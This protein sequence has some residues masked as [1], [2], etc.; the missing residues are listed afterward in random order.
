MEGTPHP[1]VLD[2]TGHDI[3]GEAAQLAGH[4]PATLVELPG[5]MVA[6]SIISQKCVRTFVGISRSVKGRVNEPAAACRGW[7]RS[8]R[9]GATIA[10][11]GFG[12]SPRTGAIGGN[13][14]RRI[15]EIN[16]AARVGPGVPERGHGSGD[17]LAS[18]AR[19]GPAAEG[20]RMITE[21]DVKAP[22]VVHIVIVIVIDAPLQRVWQLLTEV[23]SWPDWQPDITAA[24]GDRPLR[25]DSTFYW[26]TIGLDIE[27]TVYLLQSPRRILWGGT[28][29]GITGIHLWTF[30]AIGSSVH[31]HT[32][33]SWNGHP[34][35]ANVDG[36]RA[37]FGESLAAWLSH[38]KKAAE[39]S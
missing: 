38:L 33:E 36:M 28:A 26:S 1:F 12:G 30:D 22:V 3:H 24:A 2:P 20:E 37:A 23:S 8:G 21:I 18:A 27:S 19:R 13:R 29:H 31:V 25:T 14:T 39:S 9:P 34:V 5:E 32:E 17:R 4:G 11:H 7:R 15:R 10:G 35:L 6:W 16:A